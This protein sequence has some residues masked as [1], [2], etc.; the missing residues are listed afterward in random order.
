VFQVSLVKDLENACWVSSSSSLEKLALL[1]VAQNTSPL[2]WVASGES[3]VW[4]A[5]PVACSYTIGI[6]PACPVP[7][8]A[9]TCDMASGTVLAIASATI[10]SMS[11]LDRGSPT[12]AVWIGMSGCF[13]LSYKG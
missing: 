10:F 3:G 7:C 4:V 12:P 5:K 8:A 1:P 6:V 13:Y 11:D 9:I 2:D